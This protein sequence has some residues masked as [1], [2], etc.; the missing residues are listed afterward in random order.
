MF[1]DFL[2]LLRN[3]YLYLPCQPYYYIA[4]LVVNLVSLI[5]FR[6]PVLILERRQAEGSL[7]GSPKRDENDESQRSFSM[8]I[9]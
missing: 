8:V 9:N 6:E 7:I 4:L 1:L 3:R 5:I 2:H